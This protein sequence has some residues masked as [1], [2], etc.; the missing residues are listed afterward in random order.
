M[1]GSLRITLTLLAGLLLAI[2]VRTLRAAAGETQAPPDRGPLFRVVGSIYDV[3]PD[4]LRAIAKVESGGRADAVS[5]AGAVGLMQL[6]PDT[7]RS[8]DVSD[9]RDPA[10]NVL[11]AARFI[12][13]LRERD[14]CAADSTGSIALILAAYNAGPAAV[15][16]YGGT[17]PYRETRA[18]V[19]RVLWAYL[20]GSL[21]P[22]TRR[23]SASRRISNLVPPHRPNAELSILHQF[24]AIRRARAPELTSTSLHDQGLR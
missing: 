9:P 8:L 11:G 4:L 5:A 12:A 6:M 20:E 19:G 13:D 22:P 18:Y 23:S 3:D 1:T 14:L 15:C 10:Q 7:A 24:D 2:P 17:P 16:N 21:P